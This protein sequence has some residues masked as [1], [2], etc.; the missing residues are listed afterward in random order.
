MGQSGPFDGETNFADWR[1]ADGLTM[2]YKHQNQQNGQPT[3]A[4]E[5]KKIEINAAVDPKIFEMPEKPA[6]KQ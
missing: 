3:S 4:A 6:A 2:P 5:F 1:S